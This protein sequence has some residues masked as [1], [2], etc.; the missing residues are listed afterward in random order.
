[1]NRKINLMRL[2]ILLLLS[3]CLAACAGP[4]NPKPGATLSGIISIDRAKSGRIS[5]KVSDDGAAVEQVSVSF[6]D[7][8]CEG[9]SAGSSST[10]VG[11]RTPIVD[12]KFMFKSSSIGEVN[13]QFKSPTEIK[14]T[15]HLAFYDGQVEC[16]TWDWSVGE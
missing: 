3:T 14:G 16:G 12:G 9:F 13:G 11:S 5:V 1:M 4:V 2:G 7:I 8:E 10:T 6:T 15:L